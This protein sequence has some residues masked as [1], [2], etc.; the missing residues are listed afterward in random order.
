VTDTALR[1][2]S[3]TLTAFDEG[4][5]Q[6]TP[7]HRRLVCLVAS[8]G[9]L[10]IWGKDGARGNIDSVL[11]AGLPCRVDCEYRVPNE[12][13]A[14]KFGHRY[15]VREDSRLTIKMHR[16]RTSPAQGALIQGPGEPLKPDETV[17]RYFISRRDQSG[18]A[19]IDDES[20]LEQTS[21]CFRLNM[22]SGEVFFAASDP[23]EQVHRGVR[24]ARVPSPATDVDDV[25]DNDDWEA[26]EQLLGRPAADSFDD[27]SGPGAWPGPNADDAQP[28][29]YEDSVGDLEDPENHGPE[30]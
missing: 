18:R 16:D 15:W 14:A 4:G 8:G 23:I 11:R 2:G 27:F 3:F 24:R 5:V 29:D 10:A 20:W 17:E 6:G 9:K 26:E 21:G 1:S 12:T 13:H 7:D 30:N 28:E 22:A 25:D 19:W